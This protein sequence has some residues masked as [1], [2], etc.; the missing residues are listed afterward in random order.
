M[1]RGARAAG[2]AAVVAATTAVFMGGVLTDVARAD[3][4]G[5]R[6]RRGDVSITQRNG[7]T[8]IRASDGSIIDYRSFNIGSGE[9]VRFIQ[10][11]E[12]ARVLNRITGD[13]PTVIEGA[14]RAN[15]QV[16]LVN[17]AGISFTRGATIN[18][19]GLHAAAG[20][21][22]NGAFLRGVSHFTNLEGEVFN[23]G[24]IRAGQVH[25]AGQR[26]VN[27][28]AI[29]SPRGIVTMVAGDEVLIRQHGERITVRVDGRTLTDQTQPHAG[30]TRPDEQAAPGVSNSG[31][32]DAR[33]GQV[34][35]GAGD[36]YALG[37]H[38]TGSLRAAG[39]RVTA[40]A[41]DGAIINE[42]DI[43]AS[44]AAGRAGR[45]TVQA[46]SVSNKGQI[47]ADADQGVAGFVEVTSRN[48]TLLH[49]GSRVS[50]AGGAG[51]AHGG[52]VLIHSYDGLT[53]HGT[54]AMVDVSG[55]AIGGRGGF[56]E[57]SGL[58]LVMNGGVDLSSVE[59]GM[60]GTLLIDPWDVRISNTGTHDGFLLD[61]F[62]DFNEG[63]M[64]NIR[65]SAAAIEAIVG[66]II[67]Q[68]TNDLFVN[69][70][71]NLV[72]G[73]NV[74]LE[75][76]RHLVYNKPIRGA[77]DLTLHANA[78][79]GL[80]GDI[81]INAPLEVAG[82]LRL[83]G[84]RSFFLNHASLLA[85]GDIEIG[86]AIDSRVVMGAHLGL[87][88][89]M[90]RFLS[91]IDGH[92]FDLTISGAARF[93]DSVGELSPVRILTVI[94]PA[95]V[96]GE[97]MQAD[98]SIRMRDDLSIADTV[99]FRAPQV[100]FAG[101]VDS[102]GGP[103]GLMVEGSTFFI[104]PVGSASPLRSVMVQGPLS[105]RGHLVRTTRS[106]HYAGPVQVGGP[107]VF[108][109]YSIRFFDR[110]DGATFLS[111]SIH[112]RG[113]AFFGG[114]VGEM[115]D[116]E[117]LTVDGWARLNGGL[118]RTL[119]DQHYGRNALLGADTVL[120]SV[121]S[122][123]IRFAGA[124]DGPFDLAIETAGTTR[125]DRS[126]GGRVP[127]DR[128]TT[129]AGGSTQARGRI[130]ARAI[131]LGDRLTLSGDL[132]LA[133]MDWVDIGDGADGAGADLRILSPETRLRGDLLDLGRFTTDAAGSTWIDADRIQARSIRF[134][135]A[136]L[137][138]RN[139][140]MEATEFI[141][142]GSV[143]DG[144]FALTLQTPGVTRF[145]GLVGSVTP[146]DA[147]ITDAGGV[148][149]LPLAMNA[150]IVD[151][152][153]RVILSGDSTLTGADS[154]TLRSGLRGHGGDLHLASP[155]TRLHG[156]FSDLGLLE[157]DADGMTILDAPLIRTTEAQFHDMV[158]LGGATR[159]NSTGDATFAST[160]DGGFD[161]DLTAAGRVMLGGA[162]GGIESLRSLD[163]AS[164]GVIHL[165]GGLVRTL[166]NLSLRGGVSHVGPAVATITGLGPDGSLVFRSANGW[167]TLGRGSRVTALG[168]LIIEGG[169]GA[170]VGD[171]NAM[172]D[173]RVIAPVIQIRTR[174][175]GDVL[176]RDGGVTRDSRVDIIAGGGIDFSV[177]PA[178]LGFGRE[179]VLATTTGEGIS[180]TLM[181]FSA[182]SFE[183]LDASW[184]TF[185]DT[186][187]DLVAPP[188]AII[189][190]PPPPPPPVTGAN[191]AT[192]EPSDGP[193]PDGGRARDL[194]LL[195]PVVRRNL[196]RLAIYT[197]ELDR[198][199]L[200][201][202]AQASALMDDASRV[203]PSGVIDRAPTVVNR[204]SRDLV[205]EAL[206]A[207]ATLFFAEPTT[208][209]TDF[210]QRADRAAEIRAALASAIQRDGATADEVDALRRILT[211][212]RA[213]GLTRAEYERSRRAVLAPITP[214]GVSEARM[215]ELVEGPVS[216]TF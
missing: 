22:T 155:Q 172:G 189:P 60:A 184:F 123:S 56:A 153:D 208:V 55:G 85:G 39:G 84:A 134:G 132:A 130:N 198:A 163:V 196:E 31:T 128:L 99:M 197:R 170:A 35:L 26:V 150:R 115:Y 12:F 63:G 49:G 116:L 105:M 118:V 175:G 51:T 143:L 114:A 40:A 92:G 183:D 25:L 88:A 45:V 86:S 121:D 9:M 190:P 199:E 77:N 102:L 149:R 76:G 110:L 135:D 7:R 124:L 137:L 161:L 53:V 23:A 100:V 120:R 166:E 103:H 37:I 15:G 117:S 38:N 191:P 111:D 10:P 148:T 58:S 4:D 41:S 133:G 182:R 136:A 46:P 164:G 68:A 30:A 206:A 188:P 139:G 89:P 113:N 32:V 34:V 90:T 97:L 177:E 151:L 11:G 65:L 72:H 213:S 44:V 6:V 214:E 98:L 19:G 79:G 138:V 36:L 93:D 81:T 27:E 169:A 186:V 101:A 1:R 43:S 71:V 95:Q 104:G 48:H 174:V 28:G 200:V 29:A 18:V 167:V 203:G 8:I 127:L 73:N 204:L 16:Y 144:P 126:V 141:R 80:D 131:E 142:F 215:L 146:L 180:A 112:V 195:D 2:R 108:E 210:A 5:A 3:V 106:Q 78:L 20:T 21:M 171:L 187:L 74:R 156:V 212:L 50:A 194:L 176:N 125:F 62:V 24:S 145:D 209:D 140:V 75:A 67:I 64:I 57:I 47:S 119:G 205:L 14:L 59:P 122:G 168:D 107:G 147:I 192:V 185:G 211:N 201:T 178:L 54:G 129:D 193:G 207:Y 96:H 160:L 42:G 154:I 52:E 17:P 61:G 66:D 33:R 216:A 69:Y 158:M 165:D 159:I 94:G 83:Q 109:G 82:G 162:V 152:G 70:R 173:I 91:P 157:T 181:G 202:T 13:S 179:P 87:T